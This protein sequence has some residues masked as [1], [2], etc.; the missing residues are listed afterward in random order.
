MLTVITIRQSEMILECET[1]TAIS[2]AGIDTNGFVDVSSWFFKVAG[3]SLV[4]PTIP[5]ARPTTLASVRGLVRENSVGK[6]SSPDCSASMIS[7]GSNTRWIK[8]PWGE[9]GQA[10]LTMKGTENT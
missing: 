6:T 3:V 4:G 7:E 9:A 1:Q 5:D 2:V 8:T 10:L